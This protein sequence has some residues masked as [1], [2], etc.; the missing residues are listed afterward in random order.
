M[1]ASIA[2]PM[3]GIPQSSTATVSRAN[4]IQAFAT[5]PG[6]R[7]SNSPGG[8][9]DAAFGASTRSSG[10]RHSCDGR[11]NRSRTTPAARLATDEAMSTSSNPTWFDQANWVAANDPPT[12]SSAGQTASVSRQEVIVRTSQ[13]G[14][15]SDNSG[16]I[17][18]AVALRASTS[19]SVTAERVRIGVPIAPQAT[20]AVL[21]I[22]HSSAA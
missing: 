11:Q 1:W 9:S 7:W 12:T 14:T 18:P 17:R 8:R 10:N 19:R 22:R 21:A 2:L 20:G 15:I 5:R 13:T 16:K 6:V 3:S 4:G